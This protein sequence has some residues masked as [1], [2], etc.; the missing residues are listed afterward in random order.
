[1]KSLSRTKEPIE[2]YKLLKFFLILWKCLE[3]A[4]Y[5]WGKRKLF[6]E[7]IDK[8]SL[9]KEYRSVLLE[10]GCVCGTI[11]QILEDCWRHVEEKSGYCVED[12]LFLFKM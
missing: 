6:V 7:E 1:M 10:M 12:R 9:F 4:K 5:A 11:L 8:P 2:S 3:H